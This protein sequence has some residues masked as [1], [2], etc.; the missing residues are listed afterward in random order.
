MRYILA[1]LMTSF[2]LPLNAQKIWRGGHI[3]HFMFD[4]DI[5][6][7][8][9]FGNPA[10]A[11][12]FNAYLNAMYIEKEREY[13]VS[14]VNEANVDKVNEFLRRYDAKI[15]AAAVNKNY[16]AK[17]LSLKKKPMPHK[18]LTVTSYDTLPQAE[19]FVKHLMALRNKFWD[20]SG[21]LKLLRP[22]DSYPA[23]Y[24]GIFYDEDS[25]AKILRE[26]YR[27]ANQCVYRSLDLNT[28]AYLVS[29]RADNMLSIAE[30]SLEVEDMPVFYAAMDELLKILHKHVKKASIKYI[31]VN[32]APL[33][34]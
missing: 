18:S 17:L 23:R 15:K 7:L 9:D 10:D 21:K 16:Q 3:S 22:N 29:S 34:I 30:A 31:F 33:G 12:R 28:C 2:L 4:S 14:A 8:E 32:D 13:A 26:Y 6:L 11:A 19:D 25:S 27:Y 20:R 1:V 24:K 5:V